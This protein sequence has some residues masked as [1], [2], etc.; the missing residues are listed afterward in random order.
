MFGWPVWAHFTVN[1][2]YPNGANLMRNRYIEKIKQALRPPIYKLLF[3]SQQQFVCPICGYE[4]PFLDK[5]ISRVPD[6]VRSN[7]KCLG[8]AS[9]ERHRMMHLVVNKLFSSWDPGGKSLL[10]IAPEDCLTT[11]L[12]SKFAIYHTADLL[13]ENVDFNEDIQAMSFPNDSYDCLV[14]SRV[15]TIPPDL[16][17]SLKEIRRV[18]KPNGIAIVAEIFKHDE[19]L[20]FGEMINFRSRE[21]GIDLINRLEEHFSQVERYLSDSFS[22]SY[23]L[24]NTMKLNGKPQDDFPEKV[25]IKNVGFMEMVLVCHV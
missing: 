5:R 1:S 25:R 17:A 3:K 2:F 6:L 8:C 15:L 16:D 13:M 18:L 21:I 11:E 23:Q 7:S 4:G 19:I 20:E 10:H 24:A 14:V 9:N 12:N 22:S